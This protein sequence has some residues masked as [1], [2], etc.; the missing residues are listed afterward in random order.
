M[1]PE[2]KW[3]RFIAW[4]KQPS[5]IKAFILFAG[6]VGVNVDPDKM[7]EIITAATIFYGGVA[8]FYDKN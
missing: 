5:T 6:L 1:E 7:Q 3:T 4:I 2:T 8:A